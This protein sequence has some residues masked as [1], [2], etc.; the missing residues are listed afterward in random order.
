MGKFKKPRPRAEASGL[1]AR[2]R[3]GSHAGR[4]VPRKKDS[5]EYIQRE[6]ERERE[7][8]IILA[9]TPK[10]KQKVKK[11]SVPALFME[12]SVAWI[13]PAVKGEIAGN[14]GFTFNHR[15]GKTRTISRSF[16]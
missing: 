13:R 12:D 8:E 16:R 14:R 5:G 4:V 3:K 9:K 15:H 7:R 1:C 6:R 2:V 11:N 10:S